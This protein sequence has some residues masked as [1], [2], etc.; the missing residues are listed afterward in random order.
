MWCAEMSNAEGGGLESC[1]SLAAVRDQ[2][3]E[4]QYRDGKLRVLQDRCHAALG[5]YFGGVYEYLRRIRGATCGSYDEREVQRRLLEL[6]G[7]ERGCVQGCFLVDQLV[8]QEMMCT[9]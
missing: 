1:G 2:V 4:P 6:V 5:G 9:P 8:F 3:V 7:G